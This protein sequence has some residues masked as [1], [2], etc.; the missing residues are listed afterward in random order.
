MKAL[1]L[2]G[3]L[4]VLFVGFQIYQRSAANVTQGGASPQE[5]IDVTAIRQRLLTIG[6]TQKQ[7]QATHG[8]YASLEELAAQNLLPGGTE[9]RGY[10]YTAE[11]I[12]AGFIITATPTDPAKKDWPTLTIT[13]AMTVD[14]VRPR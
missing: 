1:G 2:I 3:V 5:Q 8:K 10:T 11:I 4:I 12:G 14:I 6:Q 13:E 9:Q 7:F